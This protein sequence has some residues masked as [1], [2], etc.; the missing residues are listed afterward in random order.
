MQV[1]GKT[2]P[3]KCKLEASTI[4]KC[5]GSDGKPTVAEKCGEGG[6]TVTNGDNHCSKD[7]CTCPGNGLTPVCGSD[8]P[9]S[10]GANANT[11]YRC[12]G[13]SGTKPE[14]FDICK[15]GTM[16]IKIP[17]PTGAVCGAG[18]CECTGDKERAHIRSPTTVALRRMRSTSAL[19]VASPSWSRSATPLKVVP[20]FLVVLP[21]VPASV[22]RMV[23]RAVRSSIPTARSRGPLCGPARLVSLQS[24]CRTVAMAALPRSQLL[25][26]WPSLRLSPITCAIRS[27]HVWRLDL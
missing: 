12:P 26:P 5:E 16:C 1:C 6:C 20:K 19:L 7:T 13:G 27:A 2:F 17:A 9:A 23:L 10:C 24:S 15:P 21:V 18:T 11:I 14:V 3:P 22:E 8:L 4:Y 25:P